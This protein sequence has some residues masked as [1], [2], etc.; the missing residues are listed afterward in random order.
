M[1]AV[2][3]PGGTVVPL[4]MLAFLFLAMVAGMFGFGGGNV[5]REAAAESLFVLFL[6]LLLVALLITRA[7]S[8]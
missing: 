1:Q 7:H 3:P 8:S 5:R 4:W 6:M 2:F